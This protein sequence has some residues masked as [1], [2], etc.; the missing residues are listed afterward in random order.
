MRDHLDI[1]AD[2]EPAWATQPS[3]YGQQFRD[4]YDALF[5]LD[6]AAAATADRLARL[7]PGGGSAGRFVEFGVGT[8]RVA[9]PLA[10]AGAAVTGVDLSPELLRGAADRARAAGL[11][12]DLVQGDIRQWVAPRPADVAYCI[13]ATISMLPSP[14]EHQQV[15]DGLARSVRPGGHVVIETHSPARV[16]LLHRDSATVEF[17]TAL[18]GRPVG[19]PTVSHLDAS[20]RWSLTY[21]WDDPEPREARE[22]SRL[23]EPTELAAMA[24]RAGL[25]PVAT[26]SSWTGDGLDPLDPTYIS[27]F[28]A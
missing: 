9:L 19:L 23:I 13:C 8:G 24:R 28:R 15:V 22:F 27:V 26:T 17:R 3:A 14:A 2:P 5:P 25:E 7:G 18:P 21:R 10:A 6:D 16:R 11:T 4:I 12:I 1:T 20:G